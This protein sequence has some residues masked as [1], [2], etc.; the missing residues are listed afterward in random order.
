MSFSNVYTKG[1][2]QPEIITTMAVLFQGASDS[3]KFEQQSYL[4]FKK[5]ASTKLNIG[6]S[7]FSPMKPT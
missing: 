5:V 3:E 6:G 2:F 4:I 1:V 7:K